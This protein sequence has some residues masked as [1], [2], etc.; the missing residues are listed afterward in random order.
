MFKQ[1]LK[2]K[3]QIHFVLILPLY[4]EMYL[5][6][7]KMRIFRHSAIILM[8]FEDNQVPGSFSAFM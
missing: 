2:F 7:S 6:I 5:P 8:S 1:C 3:L 4:K